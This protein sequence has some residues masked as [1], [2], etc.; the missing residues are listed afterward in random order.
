MN[1]QDQMSAFILARLR[2]IEA[3][4]AALMNRAEHREEARELVEKVLEIYARRALFEPVPD[5]EAAIALRGYRES[6][7]AIFGEYPPEK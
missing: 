5:D 7:R 3:A 1:E 6:F 4:L 2:L